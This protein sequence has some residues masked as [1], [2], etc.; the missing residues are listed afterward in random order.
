MDVSNTIICRGSQKS[1]ETCTCIR[2]A[3]SRDSPSRNSGISSRYVYKP[4]E[5]MYHSIF[6]LRTR[7][8]VGFPLRHFP[9]TVSDWLVHSS[10]PFPSSLCTSNLVSFPEDG[11]SRFLRNVGNIL[12]DYKMSHPS[13]LWTPIFNAVWT[14]PYTTLFFLTVCTERSVLLI[15]SHPPFIFL[16]VPSHTSTPPHTH[17]YIYIYI[18]TAFYWPIFRLI[19]NMYFFIVFKMSLIRIWPLRWLWSVLS[20]G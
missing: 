11:G 19:W 13:W 2:F 5:T 3:L 18:T 17:T 1:R 16:F 6:L 20:S 14:P 12:H 8:I 10:V 4:S 7:F 15:L 9:P